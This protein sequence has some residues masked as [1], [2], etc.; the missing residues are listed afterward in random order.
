LSS[1]GISETAIAKELNAP[2]S[3]FKLDYETI[4]ERI[5]ALEQINEELNDSNLGLLM[6][7]VVNYVKNLEILHENDYVLDDKEKEANKSCLTVS[8][9]VRDD[10]EILKN[11]LIDLTRKNGKYALNIFWKDPQT[12]VREVDDLIE[13]NLE[14][15]IATNPETLGYSISRLIRRVRYCEANGQPITDTT[16]QFAYANYILDERAFVKEFGARIDLPEIPDRSEIN[17][18]LPEIIGNQ[19]FVQIL[20]NSLDE[21]YNGTTNYRDIELSL[22]SNSI[23]ERLISIFEEKFQ[24]KVIGKYTYQ[25]GDIYISKN[26][27]ERNLKAIL[28]G[29]EKAHVPVDGNEN[30]IVLTTMLYNTIQDPEAISK[31]VQE[32]LGFNQEDTVGGKSLWCI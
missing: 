3:F 25:I 29:M 9:F 30:E 4:V 32:C 1:K 21:Y 7:N 24:A 19:D 11:Y 23:F 8:P 28:D 14:N 5:E 22:E 13:S 18:Q 10:I 16:G 27:L 17:A 15:I 6:S 20:V 2:N 12:L 26:K 31:V